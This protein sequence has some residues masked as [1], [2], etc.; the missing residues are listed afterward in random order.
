MKSNVILHMTPV[1]GT[2][3]AKS[4]PPKTLDGLG[5]ALLPVLM[6]KPTNS[7][8]QQI[9]NLFPKSKRAADGSM[10]ASVRLKG[11]DAPV[12]LVAKP[13]DTILQSARAADADLQEFDTTIYV[14]FKPKVGA[15][16]EGRHLHGMALSSA[17][18]ARAQASARRA[19]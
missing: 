11:I 14:D 4:F 19:A 8:V 12:L 13:L 9:R 18:G 17:A 15:R 10:T 16:G 5:Y 6:K 3:F 1:E 7:V 2:R